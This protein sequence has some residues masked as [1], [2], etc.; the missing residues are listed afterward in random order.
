MQF[1]IEKFYPSISKGLL[2]KAVNHA[3]P[4]DTISKEKVKTL[5]H[6]LKSLLFNNKSGWVKRGNPDFEV[7]IGS[8][9][10][11]EICELVGVYILNIVDEKYE[12]ERAGL[13]RDVGLACFENVSWK[14]V[15]KIFKQKFDLN[16]A[17]E[18]NLKTVVF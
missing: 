16:I 4:F 1:E 2:T 7:T 6:S 3:K 10:A 14:D 11:V 15:I 13:H 12:K 9:D 5:M 8:F 17:S 18:T